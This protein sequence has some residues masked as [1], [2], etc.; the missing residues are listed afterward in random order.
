ML[1][2]I[3]HLG[4]A[5]PSIEAALPLY[6]DV[7]GLA[8]EGVEE[9][10][11]YRVKVAF[12]RIGEARLELLEP[13]GEGMIAAFLASHGPGL[14]HV[15]YEVKDLEAAIRACEA[16]GVTMIDRAPRPGAHG[17]RVAF[18]DPRS[19]DGVVT[20]LCQPRGRRRR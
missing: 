13:T 4:I 9:V 12:L 16:R 3:A 8:F 7:L 17:A 15:A 18:V 6:R 14:H 5:V 19:A 11:S 20:E 10:H 1:E 2:R